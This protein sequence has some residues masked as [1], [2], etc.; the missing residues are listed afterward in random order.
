M[1]AGRTALAV[2]AAT[3]GIAAGRSTACPCSRRRRTSI[4][5]LE[6]RESEDDDQHAGLQDHRRRNA[7][8]RGVVPAAG[9]KQRLADSLRD[10]K[11][12]EYSISP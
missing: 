7:D 12:R 1:H 10:L 3:V 9:S 4:Q 2:V 6:A 5:G 8:Q 11:L